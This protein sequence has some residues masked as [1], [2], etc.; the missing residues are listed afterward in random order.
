MFMFVFL[1]VKCC[2]FCSTSLLF[3]FLGG[4]NVRHAKMLAKFI[5]SHWRKTVTISFVNFFFQTQIVS[6]STQQKCFSH[7]VYIFFKSTKWLSFK[8][9][10]T[11]IVFDIFKNILISKNLFRIYQKNS[12]GLQQ[13]KKILYERPIT[14]PKR[15][16]DCCFEKYFIPQT[17]TKEKHVFEE[18]LKKNN[19]TQKYTEKH[20]FLFI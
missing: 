13:I 2:E 19:K 11:Y 10:L 20:Y 1:D 12:G 18:N 6:A 15:T 3:L 16:S 7:N 4:L 5:P 8:A 17:Q 9:N 14:P